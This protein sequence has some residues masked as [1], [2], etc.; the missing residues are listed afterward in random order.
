CREHWGQIVD[1]RVK[2]RAALEQPEESAYLETGHALLGSLGSVAKQFF[3]MA[4]SQVDA[5]VDAFED[6][7]G[8]QHI[9]IPADAGIHGSKSV[10]SRIRG[11]DRQ[12]GLLS[13]LQ[14]DMLDLVD[15]GPNAVLPMAAGDD[16]LQV[17]VCHSP[18]REVDVLHDR[19]LALFDTHSDLRPTDVLVL[20]PDMDTYSPLI[21]ARFGAGGPG[22]HTIPY[23]IADR[24]VAVDATL[25]RAFANLLDLAAGRLE[26]EAVLAFLEQPTVALRWGFADNALETLRDWVRNAA[27]RWGVDAPWRSARDLPAEQANTWRS[28]FERLLLGVAMPS[29]DSA[30]LRSGRS[31]YSD[32]TPLFQHLLPAAEISGSASRDLGRFISFGEALFAA[33][34]ELNRARP[35]VEWTA[36]FEQLLTRFCAT[37]GEEESAQILRQAWQSLAEAAEAAECRDAVPLAV[38]RRALDDALAA[39]APGWA[40]FGGGVTFAALRA[41]RAVPVRVLCLLGMND[42]QFPRN[43]A[44]PGFDL[45]LAHPRAG[46]RA[47]REEDRHAFLEALLSPRDALHI[48]YVGRNVRDN[49]PLPPSSVVDELLDTLQ[50]GFLA[51]DGGPVREHLVVEHPLQAFSRRYFDGSSGLFS[52]AQG[53]A[54][55]SRAA[56]NRDHEARPFLATPLPEPELPEREIDLD[57]LIRFLLNPARHL[58]QQ[59]LGIQLEAAE[60]MVES[61]E[62]F[63]LSGL[64]RYGLDEMIVAQRLAGRDMPSALAYARADGVLPHGQAGD[65]QFRQRWQAL[66]G[67]ARQVAAATPVHDA[68][69]FSFTAHGLTLSGQLG[70]IA[71][72]GLVLWRPAKAPKGKDWLRLWLHHLALQLAAAENPGLPRES[73]LLT[74]E[75]A[76]CLQPVADAEGQL[77]ELLALWQWGQRQLLPL[78]PNTAFAYVEGKGAWRNEW[79]SEQ[80]VAEAADPWFDLAYGGQDA[81]DVLGDDFQTL[82]RQVFESILAAQ[83]DTP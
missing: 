6:I 16:S 74:L 65:A 25:H 78:F 43:P 7:A 19:L 62:P 60:G 24:P 14:A 52:Y 1:A 75:G 51:A 67:L 71:A 61:A 53:Y 48:S 45:T 57:Q 44:V 72:D 26:A 8:L 38:V 27:I 34:G 42:G 82:A 10:D 33:H 79:D 59:R 80:G 56:L 29:F 73:R 4:S 2:A 47:Y 5:Q 64:E 21:E 66:D 69:P 36:L 35:V 28:G 58:L 76:A 30:A 83:G 23:T 63:L 3:D 39:S 9:V 68:V 77:A 12:M 18:Q 22:A 37:E 40:F 11:N 32:A 50:R 17:H 46:D 81:D 31:V 70:N 15:R 49:S 41:H 55:A 54:A 20:T 13:C